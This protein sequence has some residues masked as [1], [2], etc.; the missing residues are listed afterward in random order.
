[1][2]MSRCSIALRARRSSAHPGRRRAHT[3]HGTRDHAG[4][5]RA[6]TH[7]HTHLTRGHSSS[8]MSHVRTQVS[9]I[10]YHH[11][12]PIHQTERCQWAS[13]LRHPVVLEELPAYLPCIVMQMGKYWVEDARC[14]ISLV[15]RRRDVCGVGARLGTNA[16]WRHVSDPAGVNA[17]DQNSLLIRRDATC[18][19]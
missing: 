1:M 17:I 10:N 15:E 13:P 14:A 18:L 7:L 12:R 16:T 9:R 4:P 11:D 5:R 3:S 6:F 8:A 2:W 19:G